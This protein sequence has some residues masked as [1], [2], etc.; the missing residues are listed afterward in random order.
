M[1]MIEKSTLMFVI[2]LAALA[3]PRGMIIDTETPAGQLLHKIGTETDPQQKIQLLEQFTREFPN[4]EAIGWVYGQM[5]PL[6]VKLNQPGKALEAC[7]RWLSVEPTNAAGAHSCLK[8]AEELK[9][10]SKVGQW[11][12]ATHEAAGKLLAAP[13]PKFEDEDEENEWKRSLEFARQVQQYAEYDLFAWGLQA[14]DA[15]T[16]IQLFELL[17]QK[18]PQSDYWRQALPYYFVALQQAGQ[19]SKAVAL[20]EESIAKGQANED[21]LLVAADYQ[22]NQK[23]DYAKVLDYAQQLVKIMETKQAPEGVS[24]EAWAKKKTL[25][26]GMGYWYQGIVYSMQNKYAEADKALRAALPHIEGNDQLLAAALFH[27]GVANYQ[28]GD[29][30]GDQ[31]RILDAYNFTRRCAQIKSPYQARAN[32]NLTAIQSQYRIK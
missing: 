6:Y 15:A 26:L 17:Q 1:Q 27:L 8:I 12:A 10:P 24:P 7:E 18:N 28:I 21:M 16:K 30:T 20:A 14:P 2:T 32:Q 25:M 9:D 29:K 4:H 11:A 13:P 5:P 23:K 3:Q 22:F 31:K 19:T